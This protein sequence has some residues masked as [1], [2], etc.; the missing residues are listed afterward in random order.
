LVRK[1]PVAPRF[2]SF[3]LSIAYKNKTVITLGISAS[4]STSTSQDGFY[5]ELAF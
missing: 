1:T 3:C 5:R 2:R 4:F